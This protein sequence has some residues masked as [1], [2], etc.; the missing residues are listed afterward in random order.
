MPRAPSETLAALMRGLEAVI[1]RTAPGAGGEAAG[2]ATQV[3]PT[4]PTYSL[5]GRAAVLPSTALESTTASAARIVSVTTA[6][7]RRFTPA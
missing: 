4:K 3:L 2:P 6:N 5:A 1:G 7:D